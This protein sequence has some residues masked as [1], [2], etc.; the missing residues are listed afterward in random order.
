MVSPI[1]QEGEFW[2]GGRT[3]ERQRET[4]K[5]EISPSPVEREKKVFE[6]QAPKAVEKGGGKLILL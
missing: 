1:T 5:R 4:E 3:R 2:R 6:K